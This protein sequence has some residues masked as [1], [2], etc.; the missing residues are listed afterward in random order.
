MQLQKGLS[1]LKW[2]LDNVVGEE[3]NNEEI[4]YICIVRDR[5]KYS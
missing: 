4:L 5:R 3:M 1:V 2:F